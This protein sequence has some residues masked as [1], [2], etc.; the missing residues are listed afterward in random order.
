MGIIEYYLL[1]A[2]STSITACY[3][4]FYPL[5]QKA[6]HNNVENGFT[7]NPK[8]SIVVYILVSTVVAPL[9]VLPLLFTKYA[10]AFERGLSKEILKQD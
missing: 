2:F 10:E 8:L 4:W 9:L 7:K 6:R 1:F 3:I 5:L